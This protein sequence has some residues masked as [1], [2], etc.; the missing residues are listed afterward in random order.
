MV[1]THTLPILLSM[2]KTNTRI[3]KRELLPKRV[4]TN[5]ISN[6]ENFFQ[7]SFFFFSSW[8]LPSSVL[9]GSSPTWPDLWYALVDDMDMGYVI[10]C[11]AY[12]LNWIGICV[13]DTFTSIHLSRFNNFACIICAHVYGKETNIWICIHIKWSIMIR[14][15]FIFWYDD[16]YK[17]YPG[18]MLIHKIGIK[19][20]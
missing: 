11:D 6:E 3:K 1:S 20:F 15:T 9:N 17:A 19:A 12:M 14:E 13:L 16:I 5:T 7:S 10:L 8:L 2:C 18:L 4:W